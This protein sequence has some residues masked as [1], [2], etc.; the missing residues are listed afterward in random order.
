M[1]A[2]RLAL[3]ELRR[4]TAGRLPRAALIALVLVPTLYGGLYLYANKD[5]YAG[6][7]RVPAAVVVQDAGTTLATGERLA[8]GNQVAD[9]LVRSHSFGW[10][11]VSREAAHQGVQDGTYDFA[12]IVPAGFSA[13]LAS[14]ADF[15]PRQAQ[16]QV[17]TNDANNYLSRTIANQLVAQVTKSV[18]AQVSSTAASQLLLGFSTIHDKVGTAVAGA[19]KLVDGLG[20][21][22]AGSHRLQTG[23]GQLVAGERQLVAG[24]DALSSGANQAAAGADR[25][26]SGAHRL[27]AGLQRLDA[28]TQTMP[29]D[30]RRLADGAHQVANGNARLAA[31]GNR[32]AAASETFMS[33]VVSEQ[34]QLADRLRAA[35]LTPA[36]V[37]QVLATTSGL[38]GQL[39]SANAQLQTSANQLGQLSD[40]AAQVA[41]GA[42]RLAAAAGPLHSGIQ[43]ADAGSGQLATGADDL[44]AG[45]H[46]LAAGAA[47]LTT[48]QRAALGGATALQHGATDL[49]AGLD[50]LEAGATQL[51]DGL[52][53]GLRS[54]PDPSAAARKAVAQTLGDPVGVKGLSLASAAT[55]GAGLAPFFL[56]LALWIGAYVLFLLIKPLS[57]RALAASQ[58]SWRTALGGWLAPAALGLGQVLFVYAVVLR[59]VGI[60]ARHPILLLGFMAVVS[61]TFVMIMHALSARFGSPGKFLGLVFMVLQLVSAGGTFPWQ[62]L[63]EPLHPVHQALP[64]SYAVDGIRR[65]M[66]GGSL[67]N[68]A[69]DLAVLGLYL[70]G[71]FALSTVAARKA[72]TWTAL[73]IKPE[74][75][76]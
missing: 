65:L 57:P 17:E 43:Q 74:L 2:V 45:N 47:Q 66:Y 23:A 67:A 49:T 75:A 29:A 36:Q 26:A 37:Q 73:R 52:R 70:A 56:S 64:M 16:L 35:G 68:L 3:I 60:S 15:R 48:G 30:T 5:P 46:R 14:S 8:V 19:A 1:T 55:Y 32:V 18:A 21:A 72:G 38:T 54:I 31:A 63:P 69:T 25:L 39:A 10:H 28:G 22:D 61:L 62:T 71:A 34:G 9:E 50:R 11:R 7:S 24:S 33:T 27:H 13:D 20:T 41:A 51:R 59:G 53:Q 42:D 44:A 12:L 58:P 6:L 4:V 40:G 76:L